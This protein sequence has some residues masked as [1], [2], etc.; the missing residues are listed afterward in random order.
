MKKTCDKDCKCSNCNKNSLPICILVSMLTAVLVTLIFSFGFSAILHPTD[1]S[2]S[3]YSGEF[4]KAVDAA[5]TDSNGLTVLDSGAVIDMMRVSKLSGLIFVGATNDANSETLAAKVG[6][7]V[8]T[9]LKIYR[10]NI[11]TADDVSGDDAIALAVTVGSNKNVPS[12]L[13]VVNGSIYDRLDDVNSE[14][15]LASFIA[16]YR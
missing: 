5:K 7:S 12:L 10:Y 9:D 8:S 1:S 4:D 6:Q 11:N 15:D 16:K 13:Y 2:T 3:T 14:A